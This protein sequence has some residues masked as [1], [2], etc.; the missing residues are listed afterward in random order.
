MKK[1]L[2][3]K[4]LRQSVLSF[5]ALGIFILVGIGSWDAWPI[6]I[7]REYKGN[8]IYEEDVYFLSGRWESYEGAQDSD[9]RYQGPYRILEKD[10]DGDLSSEEVVFVNGRRHG[11]SDHFDEAGKFTHSVYYNMGVRVKDML[12]SAVEA[13]DATSAYEVLQD[14]YPWLS[15]KLNVFGFEDAYLEAYL[16]TVELLLEEYALDEEYFNDYF[17]GVTSSLEETPYDSLIV[18]NESIS[19][20][21]GI[22]EMKHSELRLAVIRRFRSDGN[23]TY[24]TVQTT[25]PN[26][27]LSINEKSVEDEDFEKFCHVLD[28]CMDSRGVLDPEDI[29]FIDSVDLWFSESLMIIYEADEYDLEASYINHHPSEV[30][31][32]ALVLMYDRFEQGD[33]LKKSAREAYILNK[34]TIRLPVLST[35]FSRNISPSSVNIVGYILENGG[36][37]VE[38]NGIVWASHYSPT[39]EDQSVPSQTKTGGY[40]VTIEGLSEGSSYYARSYATNS[41]GT[42]YGNCISFVA[43]APTALL[44]HEISNLDFSI[45]PNPASTVA[46]FSFFLERAEHISLSIIDMSGRLVYEHDPGTLFLDK[47]RIQLDLS[48]LPNGLYTCL[49]SKD[50]T[51]M[52]SRN[53]VIIR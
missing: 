1:N 32:T 44:E 37:E 26:Y 30:A 25:Y 4:T 23:S 20:Y 47:N 22:Q 15:H 35:I 16:D 8:G 46:T 52:L 36:E 53:L 51:A 40:T 6:D 42:A 34:G 38:A 27:L 29:F 3:N 43:A 19:A 33:I 39:L 11:K 31:G 50:G 10:D 45:Y 14:R 28:S 12:K 7:E 18:L 2:N 9:G 49:L 48:A 17:D 24:P 21:L 13:G 41:A 5:L